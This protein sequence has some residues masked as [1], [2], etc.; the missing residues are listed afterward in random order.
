[1]YTSVNQFWGSGI[2]SMSSFQQVTR[3]C[4]VA[5]LWHSV[6]SSNLGVGA[7]TISHIILIREVAASLGVAVK[8]E[9]VGWDDPNP[10][11][12][13]DPDVS[14][15]PYRSKR[16]L[17]NKRGLL[18]IA[19][20]SDLVVD[21]CAGDSFTDSYGLKRFWIQ[22]ASKL[23]VIACRKPLILA[24]QT[25]GPYSRWWTRLIARITMRMCRR[26]V[27]R[28]DMS[29]ALAKALDPKIPLTIATDVAFLLP[30]DRDSRGDASGLVQVG[31]NVSG[32]LYEG[33]YNRG[34]D[35]SLATDYHVAIE[36]LVAYFS[37]RDD[38]KVTLFSHVIVD[39]K[40]DAVEDDFRVSEKIASKFDNVTVEPPHF[41]PQ[42]VKSRLSTMDFFF[43]SRMHACIAAFSTGV[44]IV[45]LSYSPKFEGLFQS[46]G[47]N[48]VV[49][50]RTASKQEIFDK[51]TEAFEDREA[52]EIATKKANTE[53]EKRL[54]NYRE[55]L[56][57]VFKELSAI[58]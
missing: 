48:H 42:K 16:I 12:L 25:I 38:C 17:S 37:Q 3:T 21:I 55:V 22:V 9:I 27:A 39:K 57:D 4:R 10:S 5:L 56:E 31:I 46:L 51:V 34:N 6:N 24:P 11:Y 30:C 13:E 44:P 23:V 29:A 50:C 35:F 14:Q 54:D 33:G 28:D 32:L 40:Y 52:L 1:M 47:Y 18:G 26:V 58:K 45:P 7:L 36:E 20:R 53:V 41:S 2:R 49:D 43:G 19:R 15:T 8:F